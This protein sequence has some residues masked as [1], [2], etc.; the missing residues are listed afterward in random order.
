MHIAIATWHGTS[1][2]AAMLPSIA[3]PDVAPAAAVSVAEISLSF[4]DVA[5]TAASAAAVHQ[6]PY[7]VLASAAVGNCRDDNATIT[8]A[9]MV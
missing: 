2:S 3:A 4:C 8:S 9:W 5:A 6:A 1:C 7:T